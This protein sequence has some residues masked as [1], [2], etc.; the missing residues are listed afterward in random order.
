M[1][2]TGNGCLS[3]WEG[4]SGATGGRLPYCEV[5]RHGD[6]LPYFPKQHHE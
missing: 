1:T 5:E 4:I 2:F 6:L 3:G